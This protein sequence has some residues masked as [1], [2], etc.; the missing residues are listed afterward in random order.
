[1]RY[2]RA[3]GRDPLPDRAHDALLDVGTTTGVPGLV[4]YVAL[5][6]VVGR[7]VVRA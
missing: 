1:A 4:A 3:H 6:A 5:L 2:E 7:L